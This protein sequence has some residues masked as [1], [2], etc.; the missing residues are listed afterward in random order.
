M[1]G[2]RKKKNKQT[3]I[4]Y[5]NRGTLQ[6]VLMSQFVAVDAAAS[7]FGASC[8]QLALSFTAELYENYS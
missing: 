7:N 2:K 6:L 4:T 1:G 3:H 8:S 5:F